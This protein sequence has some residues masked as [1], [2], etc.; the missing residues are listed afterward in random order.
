M[1]KAIKQTGTVDKEGKIEEYSPELQ[2]GTEVE[3]IILVNSTETDTTEYLLS[4]KANE[5]KILEAIERVEKREELITIT[6][7]EWH[8]KYKI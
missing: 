5:K 1:I 3:I 2:E 8:D 6:P 4:T 7:E